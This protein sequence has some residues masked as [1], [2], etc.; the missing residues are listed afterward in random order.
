MLFF[1]V[2]VSILHFY[3]CFF[4]FFPF[5]FFLCYLFLLYLHSKDKGLDYHASFLLINKN[6]YTY[7]YIY[8]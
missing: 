2:Y 6:S 8:N 4:P 5:Y 1:K 7:L 3:A